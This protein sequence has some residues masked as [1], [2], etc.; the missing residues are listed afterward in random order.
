VDIIC[1]LAL[2]KEEV[3][4]LACMDWWH[5]MLLRRTNLK[6]SYIFFWVICPSA[7]RILNLLWSVGNNLFCHFWAISR[8]SWLKIIDVTVGGSSEEIS[9]IGRKFRERMPKIKGNLIVKRGNTGLSLKFFRL[10]WRTML[11]NR[12]LSADVVH[13]K[14][15]SSQSNSKTLLNRAETQ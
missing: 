4:P 5:H 12:Q 1:K 9:K 7:Y 11:A 2:E 15:A 13:I 6:I 14:Y 10:D 8:P 3:T